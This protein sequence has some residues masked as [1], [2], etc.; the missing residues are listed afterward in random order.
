MNV[1]GEVAEFLQT[2]TKNISPEN[3]K[4]IK[5]VLQALIEVCVGNAENQQVVLDKQVVEPINRILQLGKQPAG[6]VNIMCIITLYV[7]VY[8]T[9]VCLYR[10]SQLMKLL[11]LRSKLKLSNFWR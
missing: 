1:V 4:Q 5:E 11:C 7:H 9:T 6:Q 8:L 10:M 3:Y 2:F